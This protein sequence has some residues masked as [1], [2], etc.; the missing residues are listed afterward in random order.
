MKFLKLVMSLVLVLSFTLSL[1]EVAHA[2]SF[3]NSVNTDTYATNDD[4][5]LESSVFSD[6]YDNSSASI[7][8]NAVSALYYRGT[9][10]PIKMGDVL[11][12]NSTSSNGLTGHAGIVV[13]ASGDVLTIN[14]YG[15]PLIVEH[16]STWNS[17]NVRV[18]RYSN[19]S[20][21]TKAAEWG[22]NYYHNYV[23]AV[24]YGL[25]N[26]IGSYEK[27]TYC[28]KIVWDAY[29]FGG[30]V[31]IDGHTPYWSGLYGPYHLLNEPNF[32]QM[33]S[34]GQNF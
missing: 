31:S 13:N 22:R 5:S 14:G 10:I 2:D 15:A 7:T 34:W 24:Y 12:S 19:A 9:S 6:V 23:G 11:V 17:K 28:S 4:F 32:T 20:V 33:T 18:M 1:K 8:T 21:A 25:V 26:T 29:Y 16:M 27:E 30:D 3:N